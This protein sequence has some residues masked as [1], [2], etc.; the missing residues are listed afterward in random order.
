MN[1]RRTYRE[2]VQALQ[3]EAHQPAAQQALDRLAKDSMG[4]P[5]GGS[6]Q[7]SWE[8]IVDFLSG[9]IQQGVDI[10]TAYPAA[11]ALLL[12]N[13]EARQSFIEL[14]EALN[15]EEVNPEPGYPAIGS[16]DLGFLRQESQ[17]NVRQLAPAR[18]KALLRRS[19]EELKSLRTPPQMAYRS[20]A[21]MPANDWLPV[22]R[23]D[24]QLNSS[25]SVALSLEIGPSPQA[26][27]L[28]LA[29]S[30]GSHSM[31]EPNPELRYRLQVSWGA[32]TQVAE[33]GDIYRHLLSPIP[34]PVIIY[35]TQISK[36]L[37]IDLEIIGHE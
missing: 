27:A 36:D 18:W 24:L 22:L 16:I 33:T 32:Y 10:S 17:A 25:L 2:W 19:L 5:K 37:A 12:A 26:G 31:I 29:L 11:Y 23:Q 4:S 30:L 9:Q 21:Q 7:Q 35:D 3:R 13:P 1:R 6:M 34:I 15:A 28:G 8:G 14:M 20:V